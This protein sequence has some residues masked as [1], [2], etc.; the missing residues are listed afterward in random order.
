MA[1]HPLL[2][3]A[4]PMSQ[5]REKGHGGPSSVHKPTWSKQ[6]KRLAPQFTAL[7]KA[8]DEE[9]A[10]LQPTLAGAPPEHVIVIE[11]A[12]PVENFVNNVKK[13]DGLEWLVELVEDQDPDED[14]FEEK[15]PKEDDGETVAKEK[16]LSG[17]LFLI[18]SNQA[19]LEQLLNFWKLYRRSNDKFPEGDGRWK[20]LFE[21]L[22]NVRTWNANDR[23]HPDVIQDWELRASEG[24]ETVRVEVE[25]WH[26]TAEHLRERAFARLT[27]L[28]QSEKGAVL[29]RVSIPEIAYSALLIELPIS[30][31][32]EILKSKDTK[33]V[34]SGEVMFFRPAPQVAIASPADLDGETSLAVSAKPAGPPV[35]A[36]LDGLPLE[37]HEALA[38]LLVVDDPDDWGSSY[39]ASSR[40]H[41]TGM[42]SLIVRGDLHAS[43][44]PLSKPVLVRPILR[45]G[46]ASQGKI[47]ERMPD[48]LLPVDLVHRAVRRIFEGEGKEPAVA[49]SVR[50]INF[51][52]GDRSR[53]F[54]SQMSPLARLLDWL[55]VKHNVLFVVS[56]GNH[57]DKHPDYLKLDIALSAFGAAQA[58]DVQHSTVRSLVEQA[59]ARRL[60][61]PAEAMNALT[62]GALQRDLGPANSAPTIRELTCSPSCPSPLSALGLGYGRSVKPDILAPGGRA[63]YKPATIP[64]G[65]AEFSVVES[66]RSPGCRVAS[67][68]KLGSVKGYANMCG[69]S[70]AAALTTREAAL[71]TDVLQH[72]A[73]PDGTIASPVDDV[74]LPVLLRALL[75]HT[76]SWGDAREIVRT[77][78]GTGIAP[79]YLKQHLARLLGYGAIDPKRAHDC[80]EERAT[81]IAVGDITTGIGQVYTLPLP[82]DLSGKKVWRRL[83]VTLAWLSPMNPATRAYRQVKMWVDPPRS[84]LR[85]HR[86]ADDKMVRRGTVQHEVL[87]GEDAS[88]F[89]TNGG[90]TV[91]VNCEKESGAKATVRYALAVSLEVAPG[92]G[93]RV[94]EQ[95]RD[96]IRSLVKVPT[97]VAASTS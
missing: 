36:L 39:P 8:F 23:L 51:S 86:L 12:G 25:L 75:V 10:K 66:E 22:R 73:L 31:V 57:L 37:Q 82:S 50:I 84:E 61:S 58:G 7:E 69:T 89:A 97:K 27:E 46:A 78:L 54:D 74:H 17:R 93:I 65:F 30:A 88:V 5:K 85:V 19:A 71:L 92:Q 94:Y 41:G 95:V 6:R 33:L 45:P 53:L 63:H 14:F 43:S 28:V 4:P 68:G 32:K 77:A 60:L 35:V 13:I 52:V 64:S 15:K 48:S 16:Q 24:A 42:A 87:E 34:H 91:V 80:T 49:P 29:S 2:V 21:L 81:A 18:M 62:V 47:D 70:N 83:T 40:V 11:T 44:G 59:H 1:D 38:G 3:F 67:P 9:T 26:R 79:H 76:S 20:S 90:L 56:A 72:L 96:G 55:A